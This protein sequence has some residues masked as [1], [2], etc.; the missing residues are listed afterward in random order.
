MALLNWALAEAA[1]RRKEVSEANAIRRSDDVVN[2]S[3]S[4]AKRWLPDVVKAN[5]AREG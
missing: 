2:I 3:Y 1:A 4:F 5:V